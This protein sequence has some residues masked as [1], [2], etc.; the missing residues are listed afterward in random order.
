MPDPEDALRDLADEE[1]DEFEDDAED[2]SGSS[3][4]LDALAEASAA[5][6]AS[7][8]ERVNE[9]DLDAYSSPMSSASRSGSGQRRVARPDVGNIGLQGA[10]I[11][12]LIAIGLIMLLLGVWAILYQAGVED[13]PMTDRTNA[14]QL[15]IIGLLGLPLSLCLFAGAAFYFFQ[16]RKA[17]RKL[18]AWE[19]KDGENEV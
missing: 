8:L 3:I 5:L 11:P 9:A 15:G 1:G 10:A 4:E 17:K 6:S 13:M 14:Q 7:G 12:A 19:A 16:Y 2:D 18:D